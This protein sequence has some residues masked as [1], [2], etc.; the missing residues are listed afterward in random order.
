MLPAGEDRVHRQAHLAEGLEEAGPLVH[1]RLA[2]PAVQ[3]GEPLGAHE[4][5]RIDHA[6]LAVHVGED[7]VE[8]DRGGRLGHHHHDHVGHG[9][10][11]EHRVAQLVERGRR[12][13]LAEPHHQQVRTEVVHVAAFETVV[14]AALL[15]S[16]VQQ[17]LVGQLGV[18]GEQRLDEQL[19]GPAD[20]VPHR[21]DHHASAE[22]HADVPGKE[23]IGQ[24]EGEPLL[25]ERPR[26]RAGLLAGA[27]DQHLDDLGRRQRAEPLGQLV[28]RD[29]IH[30]LGDQELAGLG[31]RQDLGEQL[32]HLEHAREPP[33]HRDE[34]PVLALGDL[35][36]DDVVVEVVFAVPGRHRQQLRAGRVH[37]H[38]L[39][40]ADFG[41]DVDGHTG[42]YRGRRGWG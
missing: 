4:V 39:E 27:F 2:L 5:R 18:E 20:V 40:L 15:R 11:G 24:R 22:H 42:N 16:V 29:H 17:A 19:L 33:Q 21:A 32:A 25:V 12:A 37:Q 23:E 7:H 14:A 41:G 38:G 6:E 8:V 35:E 3:H 30:R 28:R 31:L 13:P 34:L 36:I 26:D 1:A 9:A 10:V